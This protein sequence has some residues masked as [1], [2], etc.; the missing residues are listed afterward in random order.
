MKAKLVTKPQWG[1]FPGLQITVPPDV[2][3]FFGKA[4]L[5]YAWGLYQEA[6]AILE[7]LDGL[8]TDIPIFI[9]SR[10]NCLARQGLFRAE[11][12]M[13][14]Q[15]ILR[16]AAWKDKFNGRAI[17]LLRIRLALAKL[18][19]YGALRST[20]E[21]ARSVR[22]EMIHVPCECY[23]DIEVSC[24]YCTS[25]SSDGPALRSRYYCTTI[26]SSNWFR[27]FRH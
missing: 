14:N 1:L 6:N 8:C 19:A 18:K 25:A 3:E 11:A 13:L 17:I 22:A 15:Y 23:G 21:E 2:I 10:S 5:A 16:E 4:E 9:L 24:P 7:Q 27:H 12:E 20:L 26:I